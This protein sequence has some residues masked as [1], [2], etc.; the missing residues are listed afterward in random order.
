MEY[1]ARLAP[2][3][4]RL[5]LAVNTISGAES[6]ERLTAMATAL[7]LEGFEFLKH[8]AEFL[9]AGRLSTD[10]A[11]RRLPYLP[12]ERIE[13][14][15]AAWRRLHLVEGE[16]DSLAATEP[17][18]P[19]LETVLVDR[20]NVASYLWAGSDYFPAAL[21][22]VSRT[23]AGLPESFILARAHAALPPPTN[24]Y[25]GLHR[26]VTTLRYAR[27]QAH[28]EAW[29]SRDLD[30]SEIVTLTS[31]WHDQPASSSD[32]ITRLAER[33]LAFADGGL[34]VAGRR[35]REEIE[36]DTDRRNGPV[37][38]HLDDDDRENLLVS[39]AMLPGEPLR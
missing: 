12:A 17:L 18:R 16:P 29:R 31:L 24:P 13:H 5:V 37:F 8:Y 14:E 39:L 23:V 22:F 36:E 11:L 21:E 9:L 3:V 1:A 26:H 28:V 10:L 15:L 32:A 7:G 25:L 2:E 4:D 20:T 19:L 33:G 27:S 30:R 35:L 34:T 6:G 38:V